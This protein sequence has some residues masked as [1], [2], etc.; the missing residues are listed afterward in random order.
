LLWNE[1]PPHFLQH[2]IKKFR[3]R[4]G[5]FPC[6]SSGVFFQPAIFYLFVNWPR[7]FCG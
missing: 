7:F 2:W 5:F 4:V 3:A 6:A 1:C